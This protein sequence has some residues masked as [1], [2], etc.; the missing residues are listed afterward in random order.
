MA[1]IESQVEIERAPEDVFD[2]IVDMTNEL[3]WNPGVESMEKVTDGPAGQ[4][5]KYLA[6]WKQ[7]GKIEVRCVEAE[8]PRRV[9][10]VNGGPIEVD[11]AVTLEATARGTRL[12]ARFDARPRGLFRLVFPIFVMIMRRQEAE[13]MVNL[14]KALEGA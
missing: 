1:V 12:E 2:Y 5:T 9:R 10:F 4:G 11:L 14:K 8:R 7:S 6:K 3:K 13:N